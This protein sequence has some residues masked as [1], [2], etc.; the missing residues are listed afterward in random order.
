M[1]EPEPTDRPSLVRPYTLTAGRTDSRVH[2]PL[3]APVQKL[4][5][6]REP[7][8]TGHDVRAQIVELCTGSPSV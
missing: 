2:L 3:E 6:T 8:W 5:T 1:D 4:D 7:R